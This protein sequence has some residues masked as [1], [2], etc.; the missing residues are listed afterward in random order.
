[1]KTLSLLVSVFLAS[2]CAFGAASGP[3]CGGA[4]ARVWAVGVLQKPHL[5][6]HCKDAE[7]LA[8]GNENQVDVL[9]ALLKLALTVRP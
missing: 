9:A 8:F 5:V 4:T 7:G 6:L 1:M 2:G 3:L